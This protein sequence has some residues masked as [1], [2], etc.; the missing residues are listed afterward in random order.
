METKSNNKVSKWAFAAFG[1]VLV[2]LTSCVG[3]EKWTP[4]YE[5][6]P[7]DRIERITKIRIPE[8]QVTKAFI[9][10]TTFTGDFTDSLYI[11]FESM[12]SAELFEQIDSLIAAGKSG[13]H[14][15]NNE[16]SYNVTWGNGI[17]APEGEKDEEDR[18]FKLNIT[19]GEKTGLIVY[20]MW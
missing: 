4:K 18:F 11:E 12:P 5:E 13:W 3:G 10:P 20:G 7:T 2:C 14:K 19:K 16:Y 15:D 9:G 17:P 8:Y 6:W 1:L